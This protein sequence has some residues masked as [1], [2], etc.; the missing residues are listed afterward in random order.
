[1]SSFK[2]RAWSGVFFLSM[3]LAGA[4]EG[5]E[6]AF[7]S[8]EE[9]GA[10]LDKI[11]AFFPY[12]RR[13]TLA[14]SEEVEL[15]K[16]LFFDPRLSVNNAVSCAS[17]H[18]PGLAWSD[19]LP[20]A[21]GFNH[22]EGPRNT[23]SLLNVHYSKLLFWDGRAKSIS[24]AVLSAIR[25]PKEMNQGLEALDSKLRA[26]PFYARGLDRLYGRKENLPALAARALEA[27]VASLEQEP[28]SPFDRFHE[29]GAPM[30][31][32]VARGLVLF[33]G[34]AQCLRCHATPDFSDGNFHNIGL[35]SP[36]PDEGRSAVLPGPA[37][38]AAFRTPSLRNAALTAPYMHDG[39]LRTLREVVDFYDRGGDEAQGRDPAI[40]PL[41]LSAEEKEF[42]VAFLEA[43]TTPPKPAVV[44][45]LP[46][47]SFEE[48]PHATAGGISAAHQGVAHNGNSPGPS[49]LRKALTCPHPFSVEALLREASPPP[50]EQESLRAFNDLALPR[51]ALYF[52]YLA[53][54]KG[55]PRVCSALAPF[56]K[57]FTGQSVP[58]DEACR[59]WYHEMAFARALAGRT[60]DFPRICRDS[61][62]RQPTMGPNDAEFLCGLL[63]K[64]MESPS[65]VCPSLVPRYY[66]P[67]QVRACARGFKAYEGEASACDGLRGTFDL[68]AER[69]RGIALS[70][71]AIASG[72]AG[73]C[74]DSDVCRALAGR[75]MELAAA[76]SRGLEEKLCH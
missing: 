18:Q 63:E 26:I 24:E 60:E 55:D 2:R 49:L 43:L 19:G 16:Q 39:S 57:V 36:M 9:L 47:P 59:E 65:A 41:G 62:S 61:L 5:R 72:D 40:K 51:A 11:D 28:D 38:R 6:A 37:S 29:K 15:G 54:A 13:K 12:L 52:R 10:A 75:G 17:C 74:A 56:R 66:G 42:L 25:N 68:Y 3:G 58:H 50:W 45:Q 8:P 30:Q 53:L 67:H 34:K 69:C 1:M 23:P 70:R 4:A 48:R 64:N 76:I 20:R 46:A 22:Q 73:V 14:K 33:T 71:K 32:A 21:K 44:P 27:F 35:K 7:P 31:P